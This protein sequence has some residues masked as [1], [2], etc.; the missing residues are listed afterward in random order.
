MIAKEI[1]ATHIYLEL[2]NA[3]RHCG[4]GPNNEKTIDSVI[5]SYLKAAKS[6]LSDKYYVTIDCPTQY[7]H[8][9]DSVITGK[10]KK[11]FILNLTVKL[12]GINKLKKNGKNISIKLVNDVHFGGDNGGIYVSDFNDLV[13]SEKFIKWDRYNREDVEIV[14]VNKRNTK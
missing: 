7:A 3:I 11:K 1:G 14:P 10:H 13:N 9:F 12:D 6:L 8:K 2:T 5:N 4:T